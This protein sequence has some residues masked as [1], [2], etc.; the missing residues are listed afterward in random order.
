[1]KEVTELTSKAMAK[2]LNLDENCFL[3]QFGERSQL[4]SRFNY[5][6][7]CKMSKHVLGLKPHSDGTGYTIIMQDAEGLQIQKDGKW[8]N[9]SKNPHALI[10][11][12]GDQMQVKQ[13]LCLNSPFSLCL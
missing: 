5:Y 7:P 1:M 4:Q 11:L 2:S 13:K 9:V 6:L 12:M 10:V 8:L 3:E